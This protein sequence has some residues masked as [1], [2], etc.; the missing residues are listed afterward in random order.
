MFEDAIGEAES[1]L[2]G[3]LKYV[4]SYRLVRLITLSTMLPISVAK[5]C[6]HSSPKIAYLCIQGFVRRLTA[7]L[8]TL[9]E[10]TICRNAVE[11]LIEQLY[12]YVAQGGQFLSTK[13]HT[14]R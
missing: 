5:V 2:T 10:G 3:W 4:N 1:G 6:C 13:L 7:L 14:T 11:S 12:R 9:G 8:P